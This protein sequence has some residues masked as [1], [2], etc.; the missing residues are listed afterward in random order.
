[1]EN[2]E[3]EKPLGT[4]FNSINYYSISDLEKFIDNLNYDQ[5]LFCLMEC[6]NY[7]QRRGI[8]SLEEAEVISKSIRKVHKIE[9]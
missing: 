5:S 4:L 8:L 7:A 9:E 6:C 2:T 1:M 3:E